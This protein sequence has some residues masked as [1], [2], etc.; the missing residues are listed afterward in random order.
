MHVMKEG[1]L[2]TEFW[3]HQ[4][5]KDNEILSPRLPNTNGLDIISL[6]RIRRGRPT[7]TARILGKSQ[8]QKN[9]PWT[10]KRWAHETD[11]R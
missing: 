2:S 7:E 5:M 11:E 4:N 8:G 1:D 3:T 6:G 10:Q 9:S